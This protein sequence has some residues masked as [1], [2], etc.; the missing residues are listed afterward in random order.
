MDSPRAQ[1][2]AERERTGRMRPS[3]GLVALALAIVLDVAPA[4]AWRAAVTGTPPN[5]RATAVAVD[6]DGTI[7]AVG[8]TPNLAT[9]EDALAV[10]LAGDT[11]VE[12]W[13]HLVAGGAAKDDTYRAVAARDGMVV[14]VGRV[15]IPAHEGDALMTRF[16]PDG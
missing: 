15:S 9:D 13:Q 11:G 2:A 5:G 16:G 10:A 12:L 6:A 4:H 8:R 7:I 3:T 14:G 1:R